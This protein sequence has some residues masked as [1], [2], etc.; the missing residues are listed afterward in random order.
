MPLWLLYQ[1]RCSSHPSPRKEPDIV[2]L[3]THMGGLR[4]PLQHREKHSEQ[5]KVEKQVKKRIPCILAIRGF[6]DPTQSCTMV[7]AVLASESRRMVC[8]AAR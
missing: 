8:C 2:F 6:C 7:L 5:K 3:L 1:P 4:T